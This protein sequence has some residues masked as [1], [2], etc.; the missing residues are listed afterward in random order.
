MTLSFTLHVNGQSINEGMT[1]QRVAT[2][3]ITCGSRPGMNL[4]VVQAKCDGK[5]YTVTVK[6]R[7]DDGPWKLI[8]KALKA[9]QKES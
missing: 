4:Y 3:R 5:W 8:H 2:D 1:I 7:G 9:I 6:H